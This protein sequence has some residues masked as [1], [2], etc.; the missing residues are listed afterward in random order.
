L[1]TERDS[2]WNNYFQDLETWQEIDKDTKRTYPD[3]HFFSSRVGPCPHFLAV[4][5][6]TA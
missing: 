2:S 6:Q 3:M 1:S 4:T 5:P